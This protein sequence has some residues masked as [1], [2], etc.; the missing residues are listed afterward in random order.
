M[1]TA[2]TR[3]FAAASP[4]PRLRAVYAAYPWCG[5][6]FLDPKVGE[7]RVRAIIG[8]RDDWCL[9]QQVQGHLQAMRLVG[10]DATLRIV[11]EAHHSFDRSTPLEAVEE[12]SVAPGAPTA[13]IADDGA[14]IHPLHDAPDPSLCDRDVMVYGMKAGYGRRGAHIGGGGEHAA[15]FREDMMAFW[16]EALA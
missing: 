16:R 2:A 3:R 8:D 1:L 12:A 7:T 14:M 11:G 6:Q 5:H 9:P 13:Y 4:A 10:G 15:A